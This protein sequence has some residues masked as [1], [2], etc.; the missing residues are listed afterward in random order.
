MD[1]FY[2]LALTLDDLEGIFNIYILYFWESI[3]EVVFFLLLMYLEF[4]GVCGVFLVQTISW[5]CA[6]Y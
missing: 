1:I 2:L 5:W 6:L 3:L 4:K